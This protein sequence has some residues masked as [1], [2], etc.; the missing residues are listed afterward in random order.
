MKRW[1]A[2]AIFLAA[3]SLAASSAIAAAYEVQ[4]GYVDGIRSGLFFPNPWIGDAGVV[5]TDPFGCAGTGPDCGAIRVI[6]LSGSTLN[7]TDLT[8]TINFSTTFDAGSLSIPAGDSGIFV[9]NDSSDISFIPGASHS[10]LA[11]GCNGTNLTN[12]N[13]AQICP[14]VNITDSINGLNTFFDSGHVLDTGGFDFAND[15]SNE[16][17]AW[18]DIGTFGGQAGQVP[19]P[20]TLS[21]LGAG[22]VG[23]FTI[24]RRR[25]TGQ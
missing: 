19:E 9:L 4:V 8:F 24:R 22:L 23:A 2:G 1:F 21:L 3:A 7:I 5:S 18:R 17:F 6:N 20:I 10:A 12:P 13:P 25:K 14:V 16:S 15:G 11:F